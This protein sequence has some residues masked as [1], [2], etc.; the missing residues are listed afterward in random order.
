MEV[1]PWALAVSI[2]SIVVIDA[3]VR[4]LHPDLRLAVNVVVA[5]G[6]GLWVLRRRR[7]QH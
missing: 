2:A 4:R 3:T 5:F 6:Y 7:R 1:T